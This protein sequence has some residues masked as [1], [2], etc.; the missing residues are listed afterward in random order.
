MHLW[1]SLRIR[2]S[3]K[4]TYLKKLDWNLNRMK[5]DKDSQ[6]LLPQSDTDTDAKKEGSDTSSGLWI[7]LS[8]LLMLLSC[9]YCCYCC[10]GKKLLFNI[11]LLFSNITY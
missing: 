3:F 8:E 6:N 1:P 7:I 4:T 9:C 5:S 11:L 2:D 10:G